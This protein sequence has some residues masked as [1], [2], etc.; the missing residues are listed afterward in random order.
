MPDS[1]EGVLSVFRSV[2]SALEWF[3]RT[4]TSY[5]RSEEARVFA[6]PLKWLQEERGWV[7]TSARGELPSTLEFMQAPEP[8]PSI[9]ALP[10]LTEMGQAP[11]EPVILGPVLIR[12]PDRDFAFGPSG[13]IV[14][15]APSAPAV[16]LPVSIP[17]PVIA[18]SPRVPEIIQAATVATVVPTV[19]APAPAPVRV[20]EVV[21]EIPAPKVSFP[22]IDEPIQ[23]AEVVTEIP[24]AQEAGVVE[25]LA[26]AAAVKVLKD[27]LKDVDVVEDVLKP[28]DVKINEVLGGEPG[29]T[30]SARVG[31]R[32]DPVSTVIAE[33]LDTVDPGHTG[34]AL[35]NVS[36]N[37]LPCV[38]DWLQ[39]R[40]ARE[41]KR[42]R[43][44]CILKAFRK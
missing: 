36:T 12:A 41:M 29:E 25:D 5:P 1:V 21:Q 31:R 11:A 30:I 40:I 8:L 38:P 6:D 42:G 15:V 19:S 35:A 24:P 14:P 16:S 27:Q 44:P 2:P 23:P 39:R 20:P 43:I 17:A 37:M 4:G 18:E 33:A 28:I 34:R 22:E 32:E 9:Q 7:P 3:V 26:V 10:V 13:E